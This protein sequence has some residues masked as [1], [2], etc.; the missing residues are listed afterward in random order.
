MTSPSASHQYANGAVSASPSNGISSDSRTTACFVGTSARMSGV[1]VKN[2]LSGDRITTARSGAQSAPAAMEPTPTAAA[3]L[4]VDKKDVKTVSASA[5]TSVGR[6]NVN[7]RQMT[8]RPG[9]VSIARYPI[10]ASNSK[11]VRRFRQNSRPLYRRS[12]L[13]SLQDRFVNPMDALREMQRWHDQE[14]SLDEDCYPEAEQNDVDQQRMAF[15]D[16]LSDDERI[17]ES[18]LCSNGIIDI[19][20]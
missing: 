15:A 11:G 14:L 6:A 4:S 8:A 5:A 16:D 18:S 2:G 19:D 3:I 9:F 10:R 20:E 13:Y 17:E 12:S 1:D 7:E